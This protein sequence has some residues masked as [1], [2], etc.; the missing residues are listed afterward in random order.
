MDEAVEGNDDEAVVGPTVVALVDGIDAEVAVVVK[1][2]PETEAGAGAGVEFRKEKVEAV[3]KLVVP[4]VV[5]SDD[6]GA[7]KLKP[8]AT[9][10]ADEDVPL[11]DK[12]LYI[13]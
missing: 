7:T 3:G 4:V 1:E 2:K 6:E 11:N 13:E 12:L 10:G 9:T 8:E 5:V